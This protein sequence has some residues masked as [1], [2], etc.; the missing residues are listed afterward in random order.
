MSLAELEKAISTLPPEEL[1]EFSSWFEDFLAEQW[2][3]KFEADINAGKLSHLARKADED[4]EGG[5]C[6][7]L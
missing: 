7:A 1:S 6:S 5:R 2:E 4:F 3:K